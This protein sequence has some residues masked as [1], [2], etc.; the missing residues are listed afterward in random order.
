[1]LF[2]IEMLGND[3]KIH[4]YKR[5][6]VIQ[7][8]RLYSQTCVV[9]IVS[10]QLG[11]WM[12][13]IAFSEVRIKKRRWPT[14][15][16]QILTPRLLVEAEMIHINYRLFNLTKTYTVLPP[17]KPAVCK[18]LALYVNISAVSA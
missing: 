10:W 6:T 4:K 3:G 16:Q 2:G 8:Y 14:F 15:K 12:V 7:K 5:N 17:L 1:M 11:M 9:K 13:D 18:Y